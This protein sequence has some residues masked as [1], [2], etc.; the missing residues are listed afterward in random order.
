MWRAA[1]FNYLEVLQPSYAALAERALATPAAEA[2][3]QAAP[4]AAATAAAGLVLAL[5]RRAAAVP[6]VATAAAANAS[7][8]SAAA[9]A[10]PA[11]VEAA[12]RGLADVLAAAQAS[13]QAAGRQQVAAQAAQAATW[14]LREETANRLLERAIAARASGSA[15]ADVAVAADAAVMRMLESG[16]RNGIALRQRV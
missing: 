14:R 15:P 16:M 10:P 7:A 9:V 2:V 8:R 3:R 11:G 6:A 5:T 4:A 12:A 1:G 13:R